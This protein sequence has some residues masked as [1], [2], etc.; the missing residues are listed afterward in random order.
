LLRVRP[1]TPAESL[2]RAWTLPLLPL[3]ASAL[4][5][6][7]IISERGNYAKDAIHIAALGLLTALA[8]VVY[9]QWN[10]RGR[11]GVPVPARLA[12][13]A[14]LTGAMI[15]AW[16]ALHDDQALLYATRG[17]LGTRIAQVGLLFAVASYVP[18][19]VFGVAEP[20]WLSPVRFGVVA[21]SVLAMGY[22]VLRVDAHPAIDVWTVQ[23]EGARVLLS[24]R[25][26]FHDVAMVDTGPRVAH[27]VPY[28]Y[29]PTQ[30]YLT[31]PAYLL[32]GDVR[33]TMLAATL[34]AGI[35]LRKIATAGRAPGETPSLL[36]DAAPLFFW[37]TPKLPFILE[38]SWVDPLQM[39]LLTWALWAHVTKRPTM[40]AFAFGVLLSSKQTMFWAVG[41]AGVCLGFSRRQWIIV[42]GTAVAL[43]LPFVLWDPRALLYA[44]FTFVNRLPARPD[45]LTLINWAAYGFGVTIPPAIGFVLGAAAAVWGGIR[46]RGLPAYA[47]CVCL[48]YALFFLF[49]KWAF[50]NYY[51]SLASLAAVA[52]AA[53]IARGGNAMGA[54]GNAGASERARR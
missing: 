44:N 40:A 46:A 7:A 42:V 48:T 45:A 5:G 21:L 14:M 54:I 36:A 3:L 43:V 11:P 2:Q 6:W 32:T 41:L 27:D 1:A 4:F 24:G 51:F 18:F 9:T 28:V 33:Y 31:L 50:A 16:T 22:D 30:I 49:N 29:P 19:A 52:A 34:A 17:F 25:N 38:Q 20:R 37:L 26:P 23:Q 12:A 47:A 10:A 53:T 39:A 35:F 8:H 13:S 15:L